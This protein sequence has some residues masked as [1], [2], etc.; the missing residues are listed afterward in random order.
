M[1][2]GDEAKAFQESER[3]AEVGFIPLA[4]GHL[5]LA[6]AAFE[7]GAGECAGGIVGQDGDG[8]L[9]Q[10][11]FLFVSHFLPHGMMI[12]LG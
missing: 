4:I 9:S 2:F 12:C 3:F 10:D 1:C 7:L 8:G 11:L 6:D 5:A